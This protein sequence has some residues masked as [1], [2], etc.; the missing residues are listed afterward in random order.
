MNRILLGIIKRNLKPVKSAKDRAFLELYSMKL[1]EGDIAIDCGANVG[2]VSSHWCK[3]GATVYAFEPN[4]H[5]FKILEENLSD[6]P[7]AY[8]FQ[9]AV[10]DRNEQVKLYFHIASDK[11][12]LHWSTGSSLLRF[13]AN[14]LEDKFTEVEAIDLAEFVHALDKDVKILKLDVE[15]VEYNI[16]RRLIE[17]EMHM[18]I[19]HIFV[20]THEK[21]APE[22]QADTDELR[23]LIK[24]MNITNI[25]MNW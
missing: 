9:K 18:R 19:E 6:Y 16:L 15:G 12:E 20:E 13:K 10:L 14:V 5:A 25:N 11:N 7:N 24:S 4:P 8:C 17:S 22:L 21:Q 2:K 3:S 23:A 1:R